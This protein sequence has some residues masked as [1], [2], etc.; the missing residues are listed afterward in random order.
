MVLV[1]QEMDNWKK[2]F[3]KDYKVTISRIDAKIDEILKTQMGVISKW[4]Y[5]LLATNRDYFSSV[6]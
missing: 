1:I 5:N 4:L 3:Q 2:F 6:L